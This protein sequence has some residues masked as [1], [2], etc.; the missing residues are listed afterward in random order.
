MN[1]ETNKTTLKH[2]AFMNIEKYVELNFEEIRNILSFGSECGQAD[3]LKE[4]TISEIKHE[5]QRRNRSY[6]K[7][8]PTTEIFILELER[9]GVEY[10]DW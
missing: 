8:M 3:S 9:R 4:L 7:M 6:R 2:Y 10:E 1:G 5:I